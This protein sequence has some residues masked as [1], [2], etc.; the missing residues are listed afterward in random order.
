MQLEYKEGRTADDV[1]KLNFC[2]RFA[3]KE[4]KR[5]TNVKHEIG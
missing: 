3:L 1:Y 4:K 5:N 2:S